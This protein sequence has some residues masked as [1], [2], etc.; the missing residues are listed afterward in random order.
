VLKRLKLPA[1]KSEGLGLWDGK[2]AIV[3]RE[4][5]RI[6]QIDPD[7]GAILRELPI[8]YVVEPVAVTQVDAKLW[9][10]DGWLFPGNVVDPDRDPTHPQTDPFEPGTRLDPL[11]AGPLPLHFAPTSDGVWHQE[12]WVPLLIESGPDGKLLD[13][14]EKP[15]GDA[16]AGI[17]WDGKNLWALD[18]KQRR[19]CVIEK[20]H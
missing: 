14:A 19:I 15:F 18:G 13:W 9:V 7:T 1:G 11:L 10:S 6:V 16:T 4:P 5:K 12:F 20:G 2:L 8:E 3:K 17:A